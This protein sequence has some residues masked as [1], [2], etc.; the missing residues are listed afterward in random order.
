LAARVGP[1]QPA[2]RADIALKS[3]AAG[4]ARGPGPALA[5]AAASAGLRLGGGGNDHPGEAA[6]QELAAIDHRFSPT[7]EGLSQ[8]INLAGRINGTRKKGGTAGLDVATL[9]RCEGE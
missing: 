4:S 2:A 5:A 8:I 3:A 9:R 1:A 6:E 7:P